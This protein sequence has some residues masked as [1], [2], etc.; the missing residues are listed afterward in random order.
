[1]R[2]TSFVL[3][4]LSLLAAA[5]SQEGADSAR[6]D[7]APRSTID[8]N[9]DH[10]PAV[11]PPPVT[12]GATVPFGA[13]KVLIDTDEGSVIVDAEKAETPEQRQQGLMFRDSL[14]P[15]EG[16]V[17]LFFEETSGAFWMK[18]VTI[19][20]S[21]AFFDADGT[22]VAILDME[23]CEEDPCELYEPVDDDGRPVTYFGALEVNQGKFQEWG[24]EVGDRITVT[25]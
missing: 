24:V 8:L 18:N 14:G 21:I 19:P 10:V 7:P 13:A 16:M 3:V 6:R 5:C 1:M 9:P 15:D 4:T 20:L 23:P 22:I 11:S 17:F 12:P 25:H 2:F